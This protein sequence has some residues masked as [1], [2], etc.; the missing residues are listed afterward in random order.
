MSNVHTHLPVPKLYVAPRK[1]APKRIHDFLTILTRL[2]PTSALRPHRLPC[3]K[4]FICETA[5]K[6]CSAVSRTRCTCTHFS[7]ARKSSRLKALSCQ[8]TVQ[9]RES[10]R[11]GFRKQPVGCTSVEA[12][13]EPADLYCVAGIFWLAS[14]DGILTLL[15]TPVPPP[16]PPKAPHRPPS[17]AALPVYQ[18]VTSASP[19]S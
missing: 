9:V 10:V 12:D 16:R 2:S 11:A 19:P 18:T 5:V 1:L 6:P 8:H 4:S 7:G 3:L 15:C 13:R 14:Y 17:S